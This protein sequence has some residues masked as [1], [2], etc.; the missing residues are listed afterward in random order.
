MIDQQQLWDEHAAAHYE[1]PGEA[2]FAADVL[3]PTVETLRRLAA[4][5]AAV[6]FAVG[7]GRVDRPRLG[8]PIE[9]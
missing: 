4:G 6:E 5:G 3:E 1:T 8:L 9:H 7:T 2:M